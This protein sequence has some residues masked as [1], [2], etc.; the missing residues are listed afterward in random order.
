MNM[1]MGVMMSGRRQ[2]PLR[3]K[4]KSLRPRAKSRMLDFGTLTTIDCMRQAIQHVVPERG[5]ILTRHNDT[6]FSER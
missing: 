1:M 3:A 6:V 2:T 5:H 4:R